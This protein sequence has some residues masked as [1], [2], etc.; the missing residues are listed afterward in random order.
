M[1]M[2]YDEKTLLIPEITGFSVWSEL[3][4]KKWELEIL[5]PARLYQGLCDRLKISDYIPREIEYGL[6]LGRELHGH[7]H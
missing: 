5:N 1:Y 3:K 6:S 2:T 7:L 4:V